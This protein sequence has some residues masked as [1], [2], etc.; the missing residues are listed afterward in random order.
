VK[1]TRPVEV[2][3]LLTLVLLGRVQGEQGEK[4]LVAQ[5]RL[6][7]RK[8]EIVEVYFLGGI[9]YRYSFSQDNIN[10][11]CQIDFVTIGAIYRAYGYGDGQDQDQ[12]YKQTEEIEWMES[13]DD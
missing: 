13:E 3:E 1:V 9:A 10:Y 6:H 8:S 11:Y 12:G 7:R 5:C 2:E 4:R